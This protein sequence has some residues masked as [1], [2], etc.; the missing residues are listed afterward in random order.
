M[1]TLHTKKFW[2]TADGRLEVYDAR[3]ATKLSKYFK[4]FEDGRHR[5]KV[6]EEAVFRV[7]QIETNEVLSLLL[8]KNFKSYM[9]P[10]I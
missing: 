3:L 2:L 5:F 9:A 10:A 1:K 7:R 4:K 6:G 8:G